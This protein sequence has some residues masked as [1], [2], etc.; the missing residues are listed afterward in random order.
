MR[1]PVR[2]RTA[3]DSDA[4]ALVDLWSEVMRK[5]DRDQQIDDV[6]HVIDRLSA[7]PEERIV[8]AEVDDNVVGA[9]H[10]RATTRSAINLER[11]LRVSSPY[12]LPDHRRQGIGSALMRAAA[13]F[14][15]ELAVP[16]LGIA[17]RAGSRDTNR[18]M[19]RLGLGPAATFRLAP[20]A[21]VKNLLLASHRP[22]LARGGGRPLTH[23]L[24]ARRSLR[25]HQPSRI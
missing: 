4:A 2:L 21:T 25:R 8:V 7:T 16:H 23:L 14:A 19:A 1:S 17:V 11:V 22:T 15:D 20:T 6:R 5:A 9:V 12:V 10:L 13:E 3:R 18:F 24:A